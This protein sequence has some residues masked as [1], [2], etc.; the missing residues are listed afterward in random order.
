MPTVTDDLAYIAQPLRHLAVPLASL[1]LDP[2]NARQHDEKNL[3]AIKGSLSRFG[4]RLP[5]VVQKQGMIVRAGNGRVV[6]ARQ[7]GWTHIAAVVVDESEVEATA[8]AIA[9]NRTTDLSSFDDEALAKL[10]E[11]LPEDAFAATGFSDTDLK[12]L[13]DKLA[14]VEVQE[15][16]VPD[17]PEEAIT[18]PG[19]LW[20]LG[21]HALLCGDCTDPAAVRRVLGGEQAA[22]CFTDP[23]WNVAIGLDSNPRHRQRRGLANDNLGEGFEPFLA[24]FIDALT[25]SLAGD[26]YCILGASE[27]PTLDRALRDRGFHWSATIIWSK[28]QFVLGRSKYHRRY[29]PIWYGWH[30]KANSSYRGGR[31][32]D[33]VWPFDR[34]KRSEEHPTMKPVGL[35]AKAIGNSS[36][37]GDIVFDG[38][39]G[40]GSTLIACEQLKR[41]CRAIE[42]DPVFCDVIV[43][44][45]EGF[46]GQKA[47]RHSAREKAPA[48]AEALEAGS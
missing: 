28:D 10:L 8:F 44:R 38:F 2:A 19:D 22:M 40:A 16:E 12:D 42:I 20:V 31:D 27:W 5:L 7:L 29:E 48:S 24:A 11:S 30:E 41:R 1:T 15:D 46:T 36:M 26:L 18:Q 39:A 13:L 45:W 14:P 4:Q 21:D 3:A 34:P 35:A 17:P 33:D 32:Q 37:A 6:A 25:P 47:E 43:R 23:P 9:D